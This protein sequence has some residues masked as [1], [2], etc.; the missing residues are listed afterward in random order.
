MKAMAFWNPKRRAEREG[1]IRA[2]SKKG[3]QRKASKK[4]AGL[5]GPVS[6]GVELDAVTSQHGANWR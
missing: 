6:H 2:G 4:K 5:V 3:G 1:S